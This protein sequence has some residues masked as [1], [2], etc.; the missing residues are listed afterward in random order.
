MGKAEEEEEGKKEGKEINFM[1][2]N[3][4]TGVEAFEEREISLDLSSPSLH[5]SLPFGLISP[6]IHKNKLS[7]STPFD[8]GWQLCSVRT[9]ISPNRE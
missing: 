3:L 2:E 9:L 8:S 6:A 5:A 4:D 7:N 1:N